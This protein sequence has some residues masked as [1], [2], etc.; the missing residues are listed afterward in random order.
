M[1]IRNLFHQKPR[2]AFVLGGG[3]NLGAVQVGQLKALLT[4]GIIPDVVIGCS[5]GALNGAAIAGEPTLDEIDRLAELWRRLSRED[6]F[7][8][9]KLGR[10]PW[11]F[12]RNGLSAF[13]DNGLRRVIDGWLS[14]RLFEEARI[15]FWAVATSRRTGREHWFHSGDVA[16]PLL[17]STALPGVFPPVSIDGHPYIDGGVVNNVP[18]SKAY[19][20]KARRVYVLDVGSLERERREP[21]RPYEVLMHAVSIARA[22]RLRIDRENVPEGVQMIQLP[23]IDTGKLRY[24]NFTRS[25]ELIERSYRASM[26]FLSQAH[27][28]IA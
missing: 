2:T 19:E 20:L 15:P 28:Q 18:V 27:A 10:G 9:S 8:A 14:Y 7:P 4:S 25:A 12:V 16:R 3:G 1:T 21:K 23:G 6:I 11:M 13:S 26:G 17:A 24:D 22:S 5:V